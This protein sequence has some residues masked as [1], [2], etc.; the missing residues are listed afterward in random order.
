MIPLAFFGYLVV[1]YVLPWH[2]TVLFQ[3]V[4]VHAPRHFPRLVLSDGVH[5]VLNGAYYLEMWL[6][7]LGFVAVASLLEAAIRRDDPAWA[8]VFGG[9]AR[10]GL[11]RAYALLG[12]LCVGLVAIA[13]TNG[14]SPHGMLSLALALLT[15]LFLSTISPAG[16]AARRT[17][18]ASASPGASGGD[19]P[20]SPT[21][22]SV[23]ARALRPEDF[24]PFA[25]EA[26]ARRVVQAVAPGAAGLV[27]RDYEVAVPPSAGLSHRFTLH[28]PPAAYLAELARPRP[29]DSAEIVTALADSAQSAVVRRA[30]VQVSGTGDAQDRLH[31]VLAYAASLPDTPP[32]EGGPRLP[33]QVLHDGAA[34]AGEKTWL[35]A[36]LLQASG[37]RTALWRA[38]S[39]GPDAV[40][41]ADVYDPS[42][43]EAGGAVLRVPDGPAWLLFRP[44]SPAPAPS[45]G[46]LYEL[47]APP[48]PSPHS[49]RTH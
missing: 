21:T 37:L 25:P 30:A 40:A 32:A 19:R 8:G 22:I 28:L 49:L 27:A 29:T 34:T 17:A 13:V 26:L 2:R 35:A 23:E 42:P 44:G 9:F 16:R 43:G 41:V 47:T 1:F 10:G 5:P 3:W 7:W 31:R 14:Y 36:S 33:I 48:T 6:W 20:A 38:P 18:Q 46:R 39:G 11:A 4:W 45:Q 12:L 24:P 15:T